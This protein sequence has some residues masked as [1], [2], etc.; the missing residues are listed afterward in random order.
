MTDAELQELFARLERL[1]RSNR[2]WKALATV[3][4]VLFL[5]LLS[6][7][8]VASV[9]LDRQLA[10]ALQEEVRARQAAEE[11]ALRQRVADEQR[12]VS[13]AEGRRRGGQGAK[14][15]AEEARPRR[16]AEDKPGGP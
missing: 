4:G 15:Q 16:P 8:V 9:A 11:A 10:R 2:R 7:G 1:K 12:R 3:L 6:L 14:E 13:E 5:L